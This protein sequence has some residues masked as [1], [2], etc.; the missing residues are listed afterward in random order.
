MSIADKHVENVCRMG[1]GPDCCRYLVFGGDGAGCIR[2]SG[3]QA[4]MDRRADAG[5]MT[6]L[7]QNC[8]GWDEETNTEKS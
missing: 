3:L 4:L 7:G 1:Q 5:E 2:G 6:A 8:N